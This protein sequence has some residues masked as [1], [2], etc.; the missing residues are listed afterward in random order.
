MKQSTKLMLFI[1]CS[2]GIGYLIAK[3]KAK[4]IQAQTNEEISTTTAIKFNIDKLINALGGTNNIVNVEST[5]SNLKITLKDIKSIN[6]K[7]IKSLGAKG[8]FLNENR[9][10]ILFGDTSK[11]IASKINKKLN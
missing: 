6:Q 10:T 2:L 1:I 5:I 8:S 4:K 3:R 9:I 11:D 7:E